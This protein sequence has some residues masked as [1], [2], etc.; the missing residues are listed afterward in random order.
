LV[1]SPNSVSRLR[2]YDLELLLRKNFNSSLILVFD[3]IK[4][5]SIFKNE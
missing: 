2:K 1:D 3:V 5:S 4:V